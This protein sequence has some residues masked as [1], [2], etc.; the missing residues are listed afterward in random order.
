MSIIAIIALIVCPALS[1]P[2]VFA[3]LKKDKKHKKVYLFIIAIILALFSYCYKPTASEDLYA[4]HVDT[5][6]YKN[7]SMNKLTEE[8]SKKPEQLSVIYKYVISKTGNPDLLQFFAAFVCYAILLYLL[9]EYSER[10]N[11]ISALKKVAIWVF[12]ISGFHYLVITSGIFYTL[13]LEIFSLGVYIDYEKKRKILGIMCY[14]IPVFIHTCAALPLAIILL[15]KMLGSK[16]SFRNVAILSVLLMSI[17]LLMTVVLPS[18][19]NPL[20]NELSSLYTSYFGNEEKWANLHDVFTLTVYLSRLIPILIGFCLTRQKNDVSGFS[21]FMTILVVLL[22]FQTSFSIRYIHVAVLCGLPIMF[23]AI[24]DKKYGG[25]Y[26]AS[27]YMLAIPQIAYQ[28]R[29][30]AGAGKIV[31]IQK[32][33]ITNLIMT[34]GGA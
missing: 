7:M 29:Q 10:S 33:M 26:A 8:V 25:I 4:H 34:L 14:V 12:V 15:Y 22:F 28:I 5:M 3:G 9:N 23:E 32:A 24:K 20:T 2:F 21:I 16:V 13:A 18:F 6:Q 27:L 17:G 1:L 19:N 30:I 31:G 11:G